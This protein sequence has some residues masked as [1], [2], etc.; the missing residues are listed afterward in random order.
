MLQPHGYKYMPGFLDGTM[1]AM[2]LLVPFGKLDGGGA[3]CSLYYLALQ[4]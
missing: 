4:L 2:V 3:I 1:H